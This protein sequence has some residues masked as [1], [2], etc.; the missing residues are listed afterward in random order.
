MTEIVKSLQLTNRYGISVFLIK[1]YCS[2]DAHCCCVNWQWA[3]LPG[4]PGREWCMEEVSVL[5]CSLPICQIIPEQRNSYPA[6]SYDGTNLSHVKQWPFLSWSF[7]FLKI[8]ERKRKEKK[9]LL[10]SHWTK[11]IK[12][13]RTPICWSWKPLAGGAQSRGDMIFPLLSNP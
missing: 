2:S 3:A 1:I 5:S 4:S 13:N 12:Q 9:R 8:K 6:L 7:F 10:S 11:I